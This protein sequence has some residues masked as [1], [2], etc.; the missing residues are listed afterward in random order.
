MVP[1]PVV[2]ALVEY[3]A[4]SL[5]ASSWYVIFSSLFLLS[6]LMVAHMHNFFTLSRSPPLIAL[7]SYHLTF[8]YQD[9]N[10]TEA[11][12]SHVCHNVAS[13]RTPELARN[14]C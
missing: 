13:M 9:P 8:V 11:G 4:V 3:T 12:I 6:Q 2:S 7:S 5:N 10:T 1:F 14:A